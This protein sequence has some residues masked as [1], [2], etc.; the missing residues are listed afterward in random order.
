MRDA[1]GDE[2]PDTPEDWEP[3]EALVPGILAGSGRRMKDLTAPD[4]SWV[5]AGLRAMGLTVDDIADRMKCSRRLVCTV[6]ANKMT[7]VCARLQVETLHFEQELA[8]ARSTS[9]GLINDLRTA[10]AER[11]SWKAKFERLLD[12]HIT[13]GKVGT[14]SCGCPRTRYNTY[15]HP[16]TGK[17]SCREHRRLAVARHRERRACTAE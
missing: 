6:A 16:K 2:I 7:V 9:T 10:S 1:E 3:D 17:R 12:A 4:R 15:V 5:V 13:E 14:F 11:D 8:L